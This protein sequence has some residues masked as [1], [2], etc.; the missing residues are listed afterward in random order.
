MLTSHALLVPHLPT[1]LLDEHRRHHTP[2]LEAFAQISERL[3]AQSPSA[4]VVLSARWSARGP[5]LVDAGKRHRTLTDYVGL[6]VEVRYDCDGHPALSRALVEAGQQAGVRVGAARRGVD[7]GVTVPMHFLAP[8]RGLP[9]VPL[10]LSRRNAEE[11]RAW[12]RVVRGVLAA[13][14]ERVAF[15]VSGLLSYNAHA[16]SLSRDVPEARVFDEAALESLKRGDWNALT[17]PERGLIE[18]AQPE[19]ELRHLE[20]LRGFLT[21]GVPGE[22]LCYEALPGV[23]AALMV[24]PIAE[25]AEARESP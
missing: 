5:F 22:L 15:V 18:K 10:S 24:F 20:V 7:S 14:P 2:M 19:A 9:V 23:G 4:V 25:T 11:C 3:L 1:L 8:G 6:G 21:D 12:G 13:W 16:W 17:A